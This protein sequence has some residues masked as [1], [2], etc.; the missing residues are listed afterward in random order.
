MS[1]SGVSP[2]LRGQRKTELLELAAAA[3]LENYERL[4]KAE[5]EI[6]LDEFLREDE[7]EV[8]LSS[9][10]LFDQFYHDRSGLPVK[11]DSVSASGPVASDRE[12]KGIRMRT[13]RVTRAAEEMGETIAI[14]VQQT[15]QRTRSLIQS[16]S[17]PPSPAVVVDAIDSSTA[18]LRMKVG[19]VWERAAIVERAES[20]RELLSSVVSIEALVLAVE[21]FGLSSEILPF[22]YAFTLPT[23]A[24]LQSSG[25]SVWLPDLFLLLS[26]SFWAPL[27][28]WVST[29]LFAPLLLAYFFNLTLKT[30]GGHMPSRTHGLTPPA[31]QFDPLT[32]NVAKALVTYLIY[33]QDAR[34]WGFIGAESVD[35]VR[36]AVPGGPS[37]ILI[38]ASL[39]AISSIYEAVLRK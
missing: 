11:R 30:R 27:M 28:L 20:L 4:R 36:T 15:P 2:W 22:K 23:V 37:G 25:S 24:G 19:D 17:L 7:N 39:G 26:S 10:P 14:A 32:F 1:L 12:G 8:V 35:V 31:Y 5:L 34:L 6:A 16:L 29:S 3:G 9:I 18:E 21:A 33:I 13:R 38:G